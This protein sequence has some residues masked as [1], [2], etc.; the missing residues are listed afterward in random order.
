M[1]AET[2]ASWKNEKHGAQW[3]TTLETYAFPIFGKRPVDQI[4]TADVLKVLSAIWLKKP[5]TARRLRQRVRSVL[6]WAQVAY[7]LSGANPVDGVEKALPKQPERGEHFAAMP[8]GEL[9][10]FLAGLRQ[11]P[12]PEI[13]VLAFEFLILTACRTNEVLLAT[14]SEFNLT[15]RTWTIPAAR[16][17]AGEAHTVPLPSRAITLLD[18]VKRAGQGD[19]LV[20]P[21]SKRGRPLSNM[22]AIPDTLHAGRPLCIGSLWH[23]TLCRSPCRR[24]QKRHRSDQ[25]SRRFGPRAD[26]I[27]RRV[28]ANAGKARTTHMPGLQLW[29]VARQRAV[30]YCRHGPQGAGIFGAQT[31]RR[32]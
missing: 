31:H 7:G 8:Y 25:G 20:F 10:A 17:K 16:M 6:A 1:H 13:S 4:T 28:C 32:R 3:L 2:A 14:W 23:W 29:M 12:A 21:S 15:E 19:V 24:S 9:A 11:R 30:D 22:A 18:Q 26:Q 5:E 27:R